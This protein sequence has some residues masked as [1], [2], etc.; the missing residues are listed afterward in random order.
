[1]DD[2]STGAGASSSTQP[3]WDSQS[4]ALLMHGGSCID[5][6]APSLENFSCTILCR[7]IACKHTNVTTHQRSLCPYANTEKTCSG[8]LLLIT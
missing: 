3:F 6:F 8:R 2:S 7:F 4:S 1:M 5:I